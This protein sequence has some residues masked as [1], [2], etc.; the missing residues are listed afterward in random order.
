[1]VS[2]SDSAQSGAHRPTVGSTGNGV[3]IAVLDT[4]I[5]LTHPAF[6]GR[7]V[8]GYDFVDND[9]DPSE[10]GVAASKSVFTDTERTLP[11]SLL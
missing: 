2:R 10:V 6:A 8:P 4:G 7:L 11:E 5:D 9:N 1:M 3:I